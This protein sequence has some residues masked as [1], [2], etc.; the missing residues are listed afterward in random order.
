MKTTK[1]ALFSSVMALILC[2]SMLVGTT[3]AWFTDSVESGVNQI[4][5]GNLDVEVYNGLDTSAPKVDTATKLFDEIKYWEPGVVAYENLTVANL[6]NLALKY[7]LSVNFDNAAPNVN[8]DTLAKVLKVAFVKGGISGYSNDAA[9]RTAL[10]NKLTEDGAWQ[11]LASFV[12]PGKLEQQN[13]AQTYGIV[14]YWEPSDIDNDFN[15]NNGK[16]GAL[17]ID[18]GIKLVATQLDAEFDSFGPDYD[19]DAWHPAMKVYSAQDLQAAINNGETNIVLMDNIAVEESIIVAAG[20][21]VTMN[22][23]GKTL[24]ATNDAAIRANGN[25]AL[26]GEGTIKGNVGQYV[27]RAQAGSTVTVNEGIVVEGGFGAI[28]V[29]GGTLIVNGGDFSNVEVN[30][31]HYVVSVWDNGKVIINGGT[32]TFAEDQYA[33]ANGAPVI[34]TWGGGSVEI[35]GGTF[36]A[37]SGSALCYAGASVVVKGGTFMNAAAK[38]Y[39]GTVSDKVASGY[40]AVKNAD[41]SYTVLKGEVVVTNDAELIAAIAEGKTEIVLAAGNYTMPEPDL[42]GKTL[43]LRGT[44]GAVIDTSKVDERDQFVTGATLTFDGV[45]LNFGKINQMGF[46]NTASLTYKNCDINGLQFVFGESVT[47]ENCNLNS[48]G[49]EHCVWTYGAKNVSFINCDITYGDRGINCYNHN[50]VAGGK[51]TV[52]FDG[53]TFTT[54]N[55]ASLGAVEVNSVYFSVGIDVNMTDCTAPEYGQIAYISEYDTT[56]GSKTNIT[57][58]GKDVNVIMVGN[59]WANVESDAAVLKAALSSEKKNITIVLLEDVAIDIGTGW[60]MG[61]VNTESITIDGNGKVLTLSSTYRSYFN[62]ANAEGV[63][64]LKNMTLTN[65]HK[66]THFF[67][68][69]THFNCD[70]VAE[71]VVFAKS[72]L[73]SGGAT[74]VFNDCAFSQAGTDIYGLWIMSGTNVTVNGG[75]LTTDRGFKIA[76]EDSAKELTKLT[77]SGTKFNN[78][79]KAAILVTTNYGAEITLSNVDI[80]NCKADSTNAVWIDDGRT[81]TADKIT[82]TGGSVI[83]EP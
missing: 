77:V 13:D 30:A 1:R 10:I 78:S 66:G 76:D 55:A 60:K 27:V 70:V 23:N 34:G 63:L 67:D 31:S 32:F 20:T 64:N 9:G 4:I 75:E 51:Q 69:T 26:T 83:T 7:Q 41:G 15:M 49:A 28:A 82:V 12:E 73:V 16:G 65:A 21:T 19:E 56:A 50:D 37:F 52:S 39:G 79:K 40:K 46:A 44:K 36:D 48:N 3:F 14:I 35:N 58:D 47:F 43:V 18:L 29:P 38:T 62:L 53:C 22:L 54:D 33:N 81:A 5:A 25:L 6:G 57:V 24:E 17:S 42:R 71:N 72:P 8:G 68:Y 61:G 11:P 2:F 59:K 80:T 74:A 45:T